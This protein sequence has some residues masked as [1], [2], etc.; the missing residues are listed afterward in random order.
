M[1]E[2]RK[3]VVLGANGTMGAGASG[4]FAARGFEV[5][6][7]ARTVDKAHQ[8]LG[9]VKE[10]LRT[11]VLAKSVRSGS[12]ERDLERAVAEADLIFEAVSEEMSVKR[13][14]LERVDKA[15]TAGSVV[16]TV[17]SGL[18][19]AEMCAG[20][21]DD[22]Q[23][24]FMGM[25]LFNPPHV[26]VGTEMIPGAK[27]DREVFQA[28]CLL[29]KRRLGRAVVEC[30]DMPAFA[31]NRVGFK[32]LNECALLA[33]VHGVGTI[34]YLIG[35]HTGRA[36]APLATID[37]VG[38]D[39]HQAIVDNVFANTKDE[40]HAHFQMPAYMR[41][42]MDDGHLGNKT[43]AEGGFYR[44][45]TDANGAKAVSVLDPAKRSYSE[46]AAPRP[47]KV[48]FVEEMKALHAVGRYREAVQLLLSAKGPEA[49]LTQRVIVGYVSYALNRVGKDEVVQAPADVDR[50]M[51]QGFN[52]APASA[53]VDLW[54]KGP[55]LAAMDALGLE[56]PAVVRDLPDGARLYDQPLSR[57]GRFFI[58]K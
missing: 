52:W 3:V 50:I 33:E 19:I 41:A 32:V 4:L 42:L 36:M 11:D 38:W 28:M 14:F 47:E 6:M 10:A 53:L 1:K 37:L 18:S 46:G 17:S 48:A 34:D 27:T 57:V 20:L 56:V 25:H 55:T 7:L 22:L 35:R 30:R 39:V 23:R 40:C 24:H 54:G 8:G 43:P 45:I 51:S 2:I 12:Y 49:E 31:G 13:P 58:G 16:A 9:K 26:I 44:R 15:R 5:T 21:S 29:A